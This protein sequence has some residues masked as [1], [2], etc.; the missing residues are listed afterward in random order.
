[1][2]FVISIFSVGG[3]PA[4]RETVS[5]FNL[6]T[7]PDAYKGKEIQV[8]GYLRVDLEYLSGDTNSRSFCGAL[9]HDKDTM[10]AIRVYEML[11]FCGEAVASI[12]GLHYRYVG[13]NGT[14]YPTNECPNYL[15]VFLRERPLGCLVDVTYTF[16]SEIEGLDDPF[17][18]EPQP[19]FE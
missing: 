6:V 2:A 16:R 12:E 8:I 5:F 14:F 9:M 18:E 17:P 11:R 7:N 1:M 13:V 4:D 15:S 3:Y 10:T 19:E